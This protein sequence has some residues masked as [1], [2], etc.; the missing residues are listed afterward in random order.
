MCVSIRSSSCSI[1]DRSPH[2][3]LAQVT[4]KSKTGRK[5][6]LSLLDQVTHGEAVEWS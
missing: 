1:G 3:N 6:G 5:T 2:H 4:Q